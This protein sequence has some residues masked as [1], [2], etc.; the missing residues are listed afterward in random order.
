MTIN[1]RGREWCII[2]RIEVTVIAGTLHQEAVVCPTLCSFK[3]PIVNEVR[4]QIERERGTSSHFHGQLC[5]YCICIKRIPVG[6][7]LGCAPWIM[8]HSYG[9]DR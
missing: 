2:S 6:L 1:I 3:Q 9:K 5:S 4:A 8:D 7:K